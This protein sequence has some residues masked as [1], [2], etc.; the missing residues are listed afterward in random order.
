MKTSEIIA[1]LKTISL[2]EAMWWFIEN[3][4]NNRGQRA[5]LFFYLRDRYFSEVQS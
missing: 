1:Y 4:P 5:E 2:V 3:T